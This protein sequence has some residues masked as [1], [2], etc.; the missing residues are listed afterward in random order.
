MND[1]A[2]ASNLSKAT[3]Y[4]YFTEKGELLKTIA[5]AHVSRLVDVVTKIE[6]Q[7]HAPEER[8]RALV[9]GFM[10]EYETAHHAHR[11]LTEDVRFLEPQA[12]ELILAKERRVVAAFADAIV[13][14]RPELRDAKVDKPL[15]MLLFGMINWMFTWLDA[16][17]RLSYADMSRMV[18][19]L[20]FG[21]F[22]GMPIGQPRSPA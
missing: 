22:V 13:A 16:N 2:D 5:D 1:V 15:T 19:E 17:G 4:H 20:F 7:A 9:A 3:L 10:R 8:L 18:T 14:V 12:R 11:V 6:G 21:G